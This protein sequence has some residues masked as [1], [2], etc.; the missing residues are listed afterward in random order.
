MPFATIRTH[1]ISLDETARA[2]LVHRTTDLLA[3]ILSKRPE[4]SA[5]LVEPA[6]TDATWAIGGSAQ[7]RA[8]HMEVLITAGTN[9]D[10]EKA[11]FVEAA[12]RLLAEMTPGLHEATYVVLREPAAESWGYA[13]RTQAARRAAA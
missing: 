11:R 3:G 12:H 5:V 13:G 6:S 4:V 7:R 10:A 9:T 1:G 2:A 8:A